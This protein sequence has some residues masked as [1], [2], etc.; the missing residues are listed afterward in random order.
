MANYTQKKVYKLNELNRAFKQ[1]VDREIGGKTFWVDCEVSDVTFHSSGHVYPTFVEANPED[2][3]K[4]IAKS[5]ANLWRNT[6]ERLRQKLKSTGIKLEDLLKKGNK[7]R[8]LVSFSFQE[9]YGLSLIVQDIDPTATLGDI[10]KQ[11]QFTLARIRKEGLDKYQKKLYLSPIINR[12]AV[13][14]SPD[15]SG[16]SDFMNEINTNNFYRK[17]KYKVFPTSVQGDHSVNEISSAINAAGMFNVEAIVVIR[18]GGSKMDLHVFNHYDIAKTIAY[19]PI[20]VISGVGH[21]TDNCLIDIV[22]HTALKT[23]TAAAEFLY[24]RNAVFRTNLGIS[25]DMVIKITQNIISEAM[26]ELQSKREEFVHKIIGVVRVE[27]DSLTKSEFYLNQIIQ[28]WINETKEKLDRFGRLISVNASERL[29]GANL[30][31]KNSADQL[32]YSISNIIS[33]E[34]Q[35]IERESQKVS[36]GG[37][38]CV[39][40]NLFEI[41]N[42]WNVLTLRVSRSLET[43]IRDLHHKVE[44]LEKVDPTK[45][46]A[47]GYTISTI[48]GTD[49]NKYD[50]DMNGKILISY[51]DKNEIESVIQK[52]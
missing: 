39:T 16:F 32:V 10:E 7:V 31:L 30:L 8:V 4:L 41:E 13:V 48:E 51:S 3:T 5:K 2:E 29:R 38:N 1:L 11:K 28:R 20:P 40:H 52:N 25:M 17:F 33:E 49:L 45:L 43:A 22:S 46:F 35:I 23:P 9:T 50:G 26:R 15:T 6:S 37:V 27:N 12:I 36:S 24:S 44:V 14:G 34:K 19:S 18:G 21:E 47:K 42:L